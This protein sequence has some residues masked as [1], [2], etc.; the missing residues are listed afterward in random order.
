M[1]ER[2]PTVRQPPLVHDDAS[3]RASTNANPFEAPK[4]LSLR[5]IDF[6][7]CRLPLPLQCPACGSGG[8]HSRSLGENISSPVESPHL[9]FPQ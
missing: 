2:S 9:L 4:V 6:F 5:F 1:Q 7:S 8:K 3:R